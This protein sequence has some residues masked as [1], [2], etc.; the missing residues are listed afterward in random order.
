MK[1][2]TKHNIRMAD[3]C[4]GCNAYQ[5]PDDGEAFGNCPYQDAWVDYLQVCDQF[6]RNKI[7]E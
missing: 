5:Q 6:D 2:G 1:K 4:Q 7:E 3:C